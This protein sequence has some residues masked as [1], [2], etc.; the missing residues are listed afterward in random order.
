MST[1]PTKTASQSHPNGHR[2]LHTCAFLL[3]Y[4]CL[5]PPRVTKATNGKIR[6]SVFEE[7]GKLLIGMVSMRAHWYIRNRL[8]CDQN[9]I[10]DNRSRFQ[11]WQI[12][13]MITCLDLEYPH[14]YK[15][16]TETRCGISQY[17]S[18]WKGRIA[19]KLNTEKKGDRQRQFH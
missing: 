4:F 16:I 15:M 2:Q 6:T 8:N 19:T 11:S 10:V 18:F 12:K 14:A 5:S 9:H 7:F 17:E 3:R 1:P 13:S